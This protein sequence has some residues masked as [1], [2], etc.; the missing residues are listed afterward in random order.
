MNRGKAELENKNSAGA[1]EA[2]SAA[3]EM[4]PSSAPALRNLARA[5]LLAREPE[6]ALDALTQAAR[7]EEGSVATAYLTGIA[8]A[9][10]SRFDLALPH[11]EGAVRLDPTTA[12]LRFQL[13]QAYQATGQLDKAREQFE[14]ALELDPFHTSAL[15][16]LS[17]LA[18]AAGD[19]Q[20]FGRYQAELLR[21]RQLL[22]EENRG[23][24]ALETCAYTLPESPPTEL[25]PPDDGPAVHFRDASAEPAGDDDARQ[26]LGAT[27]A[28]AITTV[29]AE[30]RPTLVV[31]TGG[32]ALY[33]VQPGAAGSLAVERLDLTLAPSPGWAA[34]LT[35]AAG[36]FHDPRPA[37]GEPFDP[38]RH[39]ATD[40]LLLS[41][42][43]AHLLRAVDGGFEDVTAAAGLAALSGRRAL[44]VDFETDGDLDLA[45]A[46]GDGL[47]LW[48]NNGDATFREVSAEVGLGGI[49]GEV[50]DLAA[51]DLS[52]NGVPD[53]VLAGAG[54]SRVYDN[55]RTG[56]FAARPQPPGPW[57][58]AR[59]V[60]VDDLDNDG[61]PDAV[62]VDTEG[63]LLIPGEGGNRERLIPSP[64]FVPTAA[65][66]LDADNDG[67][68]DLA[69]AGRSGEA[70]R[71]ALWHNRGASGWA[72]W[73][74]ATDL[75]ELALPP[76]SD[77]LAVDLDADGDTDLVAVTDGG[78]RWLPNEGGN[79]SGQLK[80]RLLGTKTNPDGFGTRVEVRQ[81]S[82]WRSRLATA[83]P[84]EIGLG[85]AGD[86]DALRVVWSNGI[87]DNEIGLPAGTGVI[88]IV[89]KNVAAGSCPFLY[90]WDG[91]GFRFVTD[92]LGG[93]PLGLSVA[94]GVPLPADPD[95]YVEI[96]GPE[97]FVAR[98]GFYGLVVTEEMREVLYLDTARLVAVDH[99]PEVEVHPTDKLGPEPFPP[100]ELWALGRPRPPRQVLA[101]DGV[102]RTE[103]VRAID[104]I[105]APP[106]PP[107]P[108]P[109]RGATEPLEL[110]LDF[111]ELD[112]RRPLVLAL[113]GWL[114]YG[115]ASTNIA[116]SQGAAEV[117]PPRLEA[118]LADGRRVTI[119]AAAGMP[120]GKTKTILVDLAGLLPPGTARLV[121]TTTFE[122]RWD[123]IALGERW[124]DAVLDL[125]SAPA[126]RAWLRFRGFS[127]VRSRAPGHPTT[128]A[129][130][131]VSELPPWETALAGWATRYGDVLP[132][133]AERDGRLALV[134][135]GDALSLS[136]P[137]RAF[138]PPA[139]GR[140]RT[141]FFYS[142]GWDKDGDANVISG[143]TIEPLPVAAEG[144]WERLYNTRPIPRDAFRRPR[145]GG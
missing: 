33:R 95:E 71:I 10:L 39:A 1:V 79:A 67:W 132:L 17:G 22:G 9:R 40:L 47:A 135:A 142:V 129:F 84:V 27:R 46:S 93:S 126:D 5:R 37:S 12:A 104:G 92:L 78:L 52:G 102:K 89:E 49:D 96:G 143:D 15:F 87:V 25:S 44:W 140:E 124:P 85:K 13:A 90:A 144:E 77:L 63:A 139:A 109:L 119:T 36:N 123:R 118:E 82:A 106:G 137:A 65:A 108:P 16:K 70:G 107:L 73:D 3:V 6:A 8:H 32:G 23:A 66:L 88:T 74:G 97:G 64:D 28:A 69:L 76:I 4:E 72:P 131:A 81:G 61:H 50:G 21:L 122:I 54:A 51:G 11:L 115:D 56:H 41:P 116:L 43:S 105:F 2:F 128:P 59:R 80:V 48:Q 94:R 20:A 26:A 145:G 121:L 86:V 138:P 125:S 62:L 57:P 83:V 14:A 68:P 30:G 134:S 136:F 117:I 24:E 133:V 53:L 18:R 112:R 34:G 45:V 58:G 100:S 120:A 99:P 130:A 101:S 75:A 98:D 60:L 103:A 127:D 113:T 55:Q 29:D 7:H 42:D 114:Q 111:G 35:A 19:L 110:T 91:T 141:F 38:A 31:V